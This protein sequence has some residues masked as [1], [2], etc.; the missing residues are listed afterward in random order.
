MLTSVTNAKVV[1]PDAVLEG[2]SVS[3]AG[4]R[5]AGASRASGSRGEGTLDAAGGYLLPGMIDLHSDAIEKQ[6]VPRARAKF[7]P[8]LVFLEMDRYFAVSGV[9]TG[10]HALCFEEGMGRSVARAR[11]H[12]DL[13]A[14]HRRE[15]RVR[16]EL[17][18]RCEVSQESAVEAVESLLRKREAMLASLMDHTPG[19]GQ[20]RDLE[21]FRQAWREEGEGSEAQIAAALKEAATAG[22]EVALNHVRRVAKAAEE[23]GAILASHDDD[24]PQ[25]VDL[26]ALEGVRVSEFPMNVAA[27]R[28]AK[29]LGMT[30]CMGAP[31]AVLGRSSGGNL[32]ALEAVELGLVDALVSDYHPPSMLQAAFKLA[33]TGLLPLPAAVGLVSNAPA[34]AAGLADRG[35]IREGALAD[36]VVVRERLGLP[37][38][39]HAVV[40]G[41]LV[42]AAD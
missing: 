29:D 28:R 25:R 32:S 11:E 1:T 27:A 22:S 2:A 21:W 33:R 31:N 10:F 6:H 41:R 36:L 5:I 3:L 35:E 39:T 38:V 18:L 34:R 12:Y 20:F 13:V 19:Q 40:G 14:R 4:D 7:S 26:L 30:V 15:G 16:H 8:E 23:H 37:I 42:F 17:H 24:S 9:T